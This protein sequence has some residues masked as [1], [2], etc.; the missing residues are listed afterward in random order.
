MKGQQG[1][2]LLEV[3]IALAIFGAI[4]VVFLNAISSGLLGANRVEELSTAE[5]IARS[6]VEY[7]KS[8]PF[9]DDDYYPIISSSPVGY[10][11]IVEVIDLSPPE[12]PDTLQKILVLVQR[13]GRNI[14]S[15]ES[16]KVKR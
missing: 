10:S 15:L 14:L 6:Q 12:Y 8:L 7:I 3:I 9:S 13:D 4:G 2:S 5:S 16:L 11:P 1:S